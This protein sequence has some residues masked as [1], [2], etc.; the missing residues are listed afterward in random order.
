MTLVSLFETTGDCVSPLDL[1]MRYGWF[2]L[3]GQCLHGQ[4]GS[5]LY[6]SYRG[7]LEAM[8]S[9]HYAILNF[10]HQQLQNL[11]KHMS[12]SIVQDLLGFVSL[13]G[14]QDA[15]YLDYH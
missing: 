7:Y 13:S 3:W 6:N 8:V 2:A 12:M 10:L 15:V 4:W 5:R 11:L 9:A 1:L 14:L